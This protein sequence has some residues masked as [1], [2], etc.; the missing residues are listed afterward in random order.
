MPMTIFDMIGALVVQ[1][2]KQRKCLTNGAV[3][4]D[5]CERNG[6]VRDSNGG[7]WLTNGKHGVILLVGSA[8]VAP[9]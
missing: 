8:A 9:A 4:Y 3:T 6:G 5:V 1:R 7:V 2:S